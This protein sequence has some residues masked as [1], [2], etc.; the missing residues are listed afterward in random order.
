MHALP[1]L[2]GQLLALDERRSQREVREH[3]HEAREHE[4]LRRDAVVVRRKNP[5]EDDGH[6]RARPLSVRARDA[7]HAGIPAANHDHIDVVIR[8]P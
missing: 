7:V 5:R 4:H 8:D 2:V 6:H 3:R 1:I